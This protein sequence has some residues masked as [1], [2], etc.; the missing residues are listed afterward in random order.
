MK[1]KMFTAS[2]C[3]L[4]TLG[5]SPVEIWALPIIQSRLVKTDPPACVN[6]TPTLFRVSPNNS[7]CP[8]TAF[9]HSGFSKSS[10]TSPG[11]LSLV[12]IWWTSLLQAM[13][14]RTASDTPNNAYDKFENTRNQSDAIGNLVT[15]WE[16]RF[17][18]RRDGRG[19]IC[20]P[21]ERA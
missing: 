9:V 14:A 15:M 4:S 20:D 19:D 11:M 5:Q 12:W 17:C 7:S 3:C 10:A 16:M 1:R 6:L 8:F 21:R 18:T 13:M 2:I